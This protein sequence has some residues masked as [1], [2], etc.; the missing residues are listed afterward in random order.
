[1]I[2][3]VG[4]L[5]R[6]KA[7][8]KFLLTIMCASTR[9]PELISLWKIAAPTIVK[10]HT[11]CFSLFGLPKVIQIDQGSNFMSKVFAQVL[12]QLDIKHCHSSTYHPE[13]QGALKR[14]HQTLNSMLC[15]YC[16]EF[17]KEW[18]EKIG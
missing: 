18:D 16:L 5:P 8:N 4:P 1:M 10:A 6:M 17:E 2:D 13:N 15:T 11:K 3:C 12:K 14:F 9:F 7:G